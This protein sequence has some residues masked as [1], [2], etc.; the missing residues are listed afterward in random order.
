MDPGTLCFEQ[1]VNK[2]VL[3]SKKFN[4][5]VSENFF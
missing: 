3:T 1:E 2:W 5:L 4:E